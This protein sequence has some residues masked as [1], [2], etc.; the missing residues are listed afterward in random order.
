MLTKNDI[1]ILDTYFKNLQTIPDE[2]E[3]IAQKIDKLN[4][5]NNA[6]DDLIELMQGES[7]DNE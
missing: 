1:D 6:N 4:I 5:I 3:I 2:L 7:S